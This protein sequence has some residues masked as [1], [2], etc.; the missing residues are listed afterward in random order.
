MRADILLPVLEKALRDKKSPIPTYLVFGMEILLS[1]YKSFLWSNTHM[2]PAHCRLQS[3][4]FA[5]EVRK[6]IEDCLPC[7]KELCFCHNR[8]DCTCLCR[9]YISDI[10]CTLRDYVQEKRFDLYHQAPWIAASHMI[11]ILY[12]SMYEGVYLCCQSNYVA[13]VLHLYNALRRVNPQMP[14]VIWLD[15]MCDVF[16]RSLFP[17]SIPNANFVSVFRRSVGGNLQKIHDSHGRSQF[18]ISRGT[19][20]SHRHAACHRLSLFYSQHMMDYQ[21]T[22]DLLVQLCEGRQISHPTTSQLKSASKQF[23]STEFTVT[24]DRIKEAV[25]PE[26]QGDLP[27]ARI[28]FFSVFSL[29]IKI[30]KELCRHLESEISA[31]C[32]FMW[33]DSLL[34]QI[35][36]HE[37]DD[38]LFRLLP[39]LRPLKKAMLPFL[40]L[41]GDQALRGFTWDI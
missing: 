39:F 20:F 31:Q 5:N 19:V 7:L 38:R 32:G 30:L 28:D 3:L 26:L 24:L 13:A 25:L 8:D 9:K 34:E 18:Q 16:H 35:S 37:Q 14:Q 4:K 23:S 2:N 29:C 40:S 27:I 15:E 17:G 6:S 33:V 41:D 11:E 10:Q 1:T 12:S 21:P 22:D 36:E